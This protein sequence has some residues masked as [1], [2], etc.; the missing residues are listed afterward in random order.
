MNRRRFLGALAGI[1]LGVVATKVAATDA[2]YL[3]SQRAYQAA[4]AETVRSQKAY[5]LTLAKHQIEAE[6]ARLQG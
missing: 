6:L 1:P 3:L 5:Q 2:A 4:C